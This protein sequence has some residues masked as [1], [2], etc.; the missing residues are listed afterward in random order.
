MNLD[1]VRMKVWITLPNREPYS[2]EVP[3]ESKRIIEEVIEEGNR[4]YQRGFVA[5][6]RDG[7]Y[8]SYVLFH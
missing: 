3:A 4:D 2:I 6:Y 1:L 7:G 8:S 5:S